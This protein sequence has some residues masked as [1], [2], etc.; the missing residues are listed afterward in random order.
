MTVDC[1]EPLVKAKCMLFKVT[2]CSPWWLM[3]TLHSHIVANHN[4]NVVAV[5]KHLANGNTTMSKCF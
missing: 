1:M 3:S 5:T 2:A 4:P